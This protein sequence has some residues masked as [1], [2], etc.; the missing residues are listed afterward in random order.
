MDTSLHT[1]H[2]LVKS[3]FGWDDYATGSVV[4]DFNKY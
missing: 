3:G 1:L 2:P 4:L